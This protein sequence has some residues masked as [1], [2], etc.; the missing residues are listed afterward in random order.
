[1]YDCVLRRSLRNT[2]EAL[3][4]SLEQLYGNSVNVTITEE[5]KQRPYS[6]QVIPVTIW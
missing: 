2:E 1:M 6:D 3:A 5:Q 4:L